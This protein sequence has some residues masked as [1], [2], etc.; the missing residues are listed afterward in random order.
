MSK[1]NVPNS[2]I[3]RDK[4]WPLSGQW[5]LLG[6]FTLVVKLCAPVG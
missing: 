3:Y 6:Q 2:E 5:P 1:H 4:K